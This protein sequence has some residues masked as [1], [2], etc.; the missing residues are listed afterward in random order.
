MGT[1]PEGRE[2]Q[3]LVDIQGSHPSGSR[4][5]H[6]NEQEIGQNGQ[7]EIFINE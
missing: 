4:K 1:G 5:V 6:P 2:I 7:R 3:E